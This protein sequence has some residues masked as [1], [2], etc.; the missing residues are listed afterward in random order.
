MPDD[1]IYDAINLFKFSRVGQG[2]SHIPGDAEYQQRYRRLAQE[3]VAKLWRLWSADEI[4]FFKL[5]QTRLGESARQTGPDIRVN[6]QLEPAM[7][8]GTY[9]TAAEQGKLAA[10]SA[11][12]VHEATH[13]VRHIASLPEEDTLCRT[14]QV[15]YF[16]ELKQG[17]TYRSRVAGAQCTARYLQTTRWY[18]SQQRNLNR[19]NSKDLV[20]YVLSIEVY[21]RDLE[22]PRTAAFIARSLSWW[23]GLRNRWPSTKGYYLRSLASQT[24]RDY[25]PPILEILESITPDQWPAV[26][27]SGGSL[28][29]IRRGLRMGHHMYSGAF[30]NRIAR[31][32]QRLRENFGIR[33]Q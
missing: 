11:I 20:D 31:V 28:D 32:Q 30:A 15:L 16:Q 24:G 1:R 7:T 27:S 23:G 6:N 19:F 29:R 4:G 5:A 2:N 10:C 9:T 13:L 22:T 33:A 17:R 12:L 3:I 25:A 21:R 8:V 26:R 18:G 14:I